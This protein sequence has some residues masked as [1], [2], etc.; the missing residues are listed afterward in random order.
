MWT[1]A[2]TASFWA[3][4]MIAMKRKGNINILSIHIGSK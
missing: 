3:D 1:T 4:G 2:K